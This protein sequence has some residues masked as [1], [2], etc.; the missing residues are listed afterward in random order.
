MHTSSNLLKFA[1]VWAD[2]DLHEVVV[3]ASSKHF[4]GETSLYVAPGQLAKLADDLSRFP[5]SPRDQ[6]EFV[7]G[8]AGLSDYGEVHG[9]VYCRDSTGHIGVHI[10]VRHTP[11]NPRDKA[12]SCVVVLQVVPSDLDRFVGALRALN[13]EGDE[14]TLGNAA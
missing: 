5:T 13:Q 7:L 10:E 8:Q 12:E 6:R 4:A 1:V 9:I 11:S 14:A 3:C 2:S